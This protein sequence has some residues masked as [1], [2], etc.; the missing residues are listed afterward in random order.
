[1]VLVGFGVGGFIEFYTFDVVKILGIEGIKFDIITNRN[2][3]YKT[4][5]N[6]NSIVSVA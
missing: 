5:C 4:I 1:M 6:V 2:S 3:S